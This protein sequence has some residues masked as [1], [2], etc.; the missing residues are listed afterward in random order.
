[1]PVDQARVGQ[2]LRQGDTHAVE[3]VLVDT[4]GRDLA[5]HLRRLN[6][7]RLLQVFELLPPARVDEVF[8]LMDGEV[9]SDL[10]QQLPVERS[11]AL[12]ERLEPDDRAW[13]SGRLPPEQAQQLM[14]ALSQDAREA[15][16]RLMRYAA[17]SAGRAMSP[18]VVAVRDTDSVGDCLEH[19]RRHGAEAETIYMLPVLDGS[20]AV[21]GVVSLRRLL[22]TAPESEVSSVMSTPVTVSAEQDQEQAAKIMRQA[23]LIA[24]P[25]IDRLGQLVG[26]LTIDD[27]MR[28]LQE[29]DAEDAARGTGSERLRRAYLATSIPDLLRARVGWLLV[30]IVAATLTVNVLDYFEETLDQ[31]VTLALF[32]PLLIGT[33]GNAGAQAATT[34]VRALAT[35]DIAPGDL[36][37]VLAREVATGLALGL[38]LGALG[39]FPASLFAGR[40]IAAVVCL[41]LVFICVLAT[42]VGAATPLLARALGIDPAVVSAPFISTIVDTTGLLVYFMIARLVLGLN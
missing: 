3:S 40:D 19:V 28:I 4:S 27:S 21:I 20:D 10:L 14:A 42:G 6:R 5:D 24:A 2:V 36:F 35:G 30:L 29:A 7:R 22:L 34:V 33:G 37:R 8:S 25:V 31:V 41:S 18:H 9:R 12:F 26:V 1:M 11:T 17:G 38:T 16:V 23:G 39:F 13:L 15:T 32:V